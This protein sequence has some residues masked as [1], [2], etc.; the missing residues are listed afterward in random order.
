MLR[1]GNGYAKSGNYHPIAANVIGHWISLWGFDDE[2]QVFYVYDPYVALS[3]HDKDIPIGNTARTFS[4]ILRDWGKG[5]PFAW[6]SGFIA[7]G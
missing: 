5:F 4:E 7:V 1:V 3:R 6:R 2:K